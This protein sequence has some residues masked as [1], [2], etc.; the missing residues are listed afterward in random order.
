[1][2]LSFRMAIACSITTL[3]TSLST[4]MDKAQNNDNSNRLYIIE[5]AG[6]P[7]E[8]MIKEVIS[9][10]SE[11]SFD[12]SPS[13]INSETISN[14][15]DY[16]GCKTKEDLAKADNKM[17]ELILSTLNQKSKEKKVLIVNLS[18]DVSSGFDSYVDHPE[19]PFKQSHLKTNYKL[20]VLSGGKTS[21]DDEE[22]EALQQS[23]MD[24]HALFVDCGKKFYRKL[25]DINNLLLIASMGNR[26]YDEYAL[27]TLVSPLR[28][29][30]LEKKLTDKAIFVV[31]TDTNN[32]IQAKSE[33]PNAA[34]LGADKLTE[35]IHMD[36]LQETKSYKTL[37]EGMS[38]RGESDN[39]GPLQA[40]T[41]AFC[42]EFENHDRTDKKERMGGTSAAAA[43][44]S[45]YASLI[46][47]DFKDL[48][49]L[50]VRECLINSTKRNFKIKFNLTDY[51]KDYQQEFEHIETLKDEEEKEAQKVA[52]ERKFWLNLFRNEG[53]HYIYIEE[54]LKKVYEFAN[55]H[56]LS[57]STISLWDF[58]GQGIVDFKRA[59]FYASILARGEHFK[60][61]DRAKLND[62][63]KKI[64]S[65]I[66]EKDLEPRRHIFEELYASERGKPYKRTGKAKQPKGNIKKVKRQPLTV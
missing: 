62:T 23:E 30:V 64:Q 49:S 13:T 28:A 14:K 21:L 48:T 57:R 40:A 63:E 46:N 15:V 9:K 55:K 8:R 3:A 59:Y 34:L 7:H 17:L 10:V 51:L 47:R 38:R 27:D 1:M 32:L 58:Y 66:L 37:K 25:A 60:E 41:V 6:S 45:T 26:V 53:S 56:H 29:S 50:Q 43:A 44:I 4:A 2:S 16:K 61:T 54:A 20:K 5:S 42:G 19:D 18:G 31:N 35:I 65:F 52:T 22:L 39:L 36:H 33:I 11:E 12:S 24:Y